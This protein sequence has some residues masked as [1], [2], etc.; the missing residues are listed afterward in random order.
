MNKQL[1][2]KVVAILGVL[3]LSCGQEAKVDKPPLPVSVRHVADFTGPGE[4]R[5]SANILPY[6]QVDLA[7]KVG[8]YVQEIHQVIGVDEKKRKVQEGDF[9]SQGTVLAQVRQSD[10]QAKLKQAQAQAAEARAGFTHASQD[11]ERA[12]KLY[13]ANALTRVDYDAA[14]A[15]YEG[16]RARVAGAA[17]Q[18]QEARIALQDTS[19]KAP[20][21]SLVL[22]RKVEVGDLVAPGAPGFALANTRE[23][24]VVFGVSDLMLKHIKPGDSLTVATEALRHRQFTGIVTALAPSADPKS[25]VFDV[26]ITIPNPSQEL[27]VGMIAAV[28]AP[29]TKPTQ[30]EL[31]VPLNAIVRGTGH[32]GSYALFVVEE[33]AG[34][35]VARRRDHLEL[36]K[37]YGNLI[38]VNRGV[39]LGESVIVTGATLVTDGQPVRVIPP[40]ER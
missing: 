7:F 8:G 31:V 10:Y 27:K 33:Q 38:A 5:Y 11:F 39:A 13:G 18:V 23:V 6:T 40:S 24:K 34:R 29:T 32:S 35:Q 22:K 1:S 36:G 21:D 12:R 37:V 9:V 4:V 28:L 15:R 25:R 14:R 30:P 16:A 17:A 2:A 26:E 3:A 19:L 20:M